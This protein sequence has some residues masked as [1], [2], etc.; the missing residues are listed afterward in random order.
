M[1]TSSSL[2]LMTSGLAAARKHLEAK[3]QRPPTEHEVKT[4]YGKDPVGYNQKGASSRG[5]RR[6]CAWCPY[7]CMHPMYVCLV[8]THL[9]CPLVFWVVWGEG[10]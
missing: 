5:E 2:R 1:I 6:V 10:R 7:A 8:P 9:P 3:M 4:E